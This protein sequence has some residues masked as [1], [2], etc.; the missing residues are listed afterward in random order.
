MYFWWPK[1]FGHFLNEKLGKIH[2]WVILVGF[3]L[4]FGPM[5][6]LGLQGMSRRIQ[7]YQESDGFHLWNFVATVG[8]FIIAVAMIVFLV[9]MAYSYRTWKAAGR[10]NPGPDPWDSRSLEWSIQ[11]PTPEHNF[12]VTPTIHAQDDFWHRKYGE[13]E[14]G[15]AVRIAKTEDVVQPGNGE[16]VH[17]PS[18][19]YFPIVLAAGMPLIGYGLIFNRLIAI[20]GAI[21][22]LF[23]LF[24]WAFEPSTEPDDGH[25]G[26]HHDH[27]GD[28]GDHGAAATAGDKEDATVG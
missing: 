17:L 20:P 12:D 10:P 14:R 16:G 24:G 3:N 2:F 15:R 5:H 11:S 26:H 27:G 18:P 7:T 23:G 6:I 22:V 1:A 25:D 13:D 9:N 4:T 19:S 21:L 8:A 28:D